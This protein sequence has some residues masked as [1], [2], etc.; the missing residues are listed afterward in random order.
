MY[1]CTQKVWQT[2]GE[3]GGCLEKKVARNRWSN[4]V[5][6]KLRP[7]LDMHGMPNNFLLWLFLTIMMKLDC[8]GIFCKLSALL[9]RG[10]SPHCRVPGTVHCP[11]SP[12]VKNSV[13]HCISL[14]NTRVKPI[15]RNLLTRKGCMPQSQTK[16][17]CTFIK[18]QM[19]PD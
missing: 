1:C 11:L 14:Y 6:P 9:S 17:K 19:L 10:D 13:F 7:E 4:R 16:F 2:I 15:G 3:S 8:H 12:P 5:S 18:M